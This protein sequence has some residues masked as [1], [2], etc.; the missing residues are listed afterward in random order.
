M[1]SAVTAA[2]WVGA[3]ASGLGAGTVG[4]AAGAVAHQVIGAGP[5]VGIAMDGLLAG[6]GCAVIVYSL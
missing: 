6:V 3:L 5:A 4:A 2:P 1:S